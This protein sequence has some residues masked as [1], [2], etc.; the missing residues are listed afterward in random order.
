MVY[1]K[2]VAIEWEDIMEDLGKRELFRE[3]D[4]R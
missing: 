4:V 1:K 2:R 3:R